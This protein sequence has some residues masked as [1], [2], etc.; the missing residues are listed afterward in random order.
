MGLMDDER[1]LE[2]SIP[3]LRRYARALTRDPAEADDLV[4][5]TLLRALDKLHT[6]RD[7]ED[8]RPWLF[9]ILH[10]Q[11]VS[12]WRRMKRALTAT[13]GPSPPEPASPPG[14]HARDDLHDARRGLMALPED[15]REVMLLVAIEGMDYSVAAAI[16]NVPLGTV[17][18]RLS[19][20]RATLR[21]WLDKQ[22]TRS[23]LRRVK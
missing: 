19:R 14:Q 4:Q 6:A 11:H 20:G 16:L 17:M 23:M 18:S 10:N 15:Q 7:R 5:D 3:A 21:T 9:T 2:A 1:R 13:M 22:E 8:L 12:R